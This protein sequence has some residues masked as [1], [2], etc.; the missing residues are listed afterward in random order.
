MKLT[1]KNKVVDSD[2]ELSIQDEIRI[3]PLMKEIVNK[4][5]D[6]LNKVDFYPFK[7]QK[8]LLAMT[9]HIIFSS[10]D[11]KNTV[12]ALNTIHERF[13]EEQIIE[14]NLFIRIVKLVV[15][16]NNIILNKSLTK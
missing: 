15:D 12:K 13:F 16:G 4:D 6:Y 5:I 11:K 1:G 8:S 9:A 10:I 14:L 2:Y 7:K 3:R